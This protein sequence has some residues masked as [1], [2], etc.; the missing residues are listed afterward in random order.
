MET[1]SVW[2]LIEFSNHPRQ[3]KWQASA[4]PVV[5]TP[6]NNN[7]PSGK[8]HNKTEWMKSIKIKRKASDRIQINELERKH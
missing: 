1:T 2:L 7:N 8:L 6:N 4:Q 3:I 5:A